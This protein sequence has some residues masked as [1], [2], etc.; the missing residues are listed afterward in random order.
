MI[1]QLGDFVA[2]FEK[3]N[4]S[5][6][7]HFQD[8]GIAKSKLGFPVQQ[9]GCLTIINLALSTSSLGA[10]QTP[11]TPLQKGQ[12][13][14]AAPRHPPGSGPRVCIP[15]D[16]PSE[17][18]KGSRKPILNH[19]QHCS[20]SGYGVSFLFFLLGLFVWDP[21]ESTLA[22]LQDTKTPAKS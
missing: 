10:Q 19:L 2:Y 21:V 5:F 12:L 8:Q 18:L 20:I 22:G 17:G 14:T 15:P 3:K 6:T 11:L 1:L 9:T 13:C 16:R 7:Q 4:I